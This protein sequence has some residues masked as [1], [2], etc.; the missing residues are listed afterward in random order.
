RA[1]ALLSRLQRAA[2]RRFHLFARSE[3]PRVAQVPP[4]SSQGGTASALGA[5]RLPAQERVSD[6]AVLVD[7]LTRIT[8]GESVLDPTIVACL[9]AL[10]KTRA[11]PH[12]SPTANARH[13]RSWRAWETTSR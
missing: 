11:S 13:S 6:I 1:P 9:L 4:G 3:R 12:N 7:A 5:Q 2:R 8:D 10:T